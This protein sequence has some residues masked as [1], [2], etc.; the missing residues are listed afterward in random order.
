MNSELIRNILFD[1]N[2]P[3]RYMGGEFNLP[4]M[5]KPCDVRVCLCF[6]DV[7]EVGMSNIGLRILYHMLNDEDRVICER[8]FAPEDDMADKMRENSIPLFSLETKRELASFDIVGFSIGYEMMYTNVLFM[9]ELA[10]IPLR[11]EDRGEDGPLVI[12]GGMCAVNGEP[13]A[14]FFD[15]ILVGEGEVNLKDLTLRYEK[16]KKDGIKKSEFLKSLVGVNGMY[17]PSI[18]KP[19]YGENGKIVAF[20]TDKVVRS[21]VKDLDKAYFPTKILVPNIEIV[22]D[23]GVLEL[24]R[25]CANGCRFCQACFYYR[26]IRERKKETLLRYA[27]EILDNT[28]YNELSLASLSTGDFSQLDS[29]IDELRPIVKERNASLSLPSLRLDSFSGKFSEDSRKGS[30][31]FAPE[32]GTQRLRNVINKNVT[33][34]NIDNTMK[35]AAEQGYKGVKLYFMIGLPT[36]TK[37]DLDGIVE[38]VKRTQEIFFKYGDRNKKPRISLST[39]VFVP[40]PLTPFEWER[41]ITV[42]EMFEKQN[43]LKSELSKLINVRY[44]YHDAYTSLIEAVLARGDRKLSRV[45]ERVYKKGSHFDAWSEHFSFD[46]WIEAMREE[47]IS[48]DEYVGGFD[49]SDILPWDNIDNGVDK[50]YLLTERKRAYAGIVTPSCIGKCNGCRANKLGRCYE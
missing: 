16:A 17:V 9:L 10:G 36:E 4:N 41:Q 39:A 3:S 22:H 26:P 6:P 38:I 12:A 24:Y 46:N 28:G 8:C 29:L 25:G 11:A 47:G 32:A 5:D 14:D 49:E 50:E 40:K 19:I 48:V 44:S 37:E 33:D 1:V 18:T 15:V 13:F 7:Y 31:T 42:D 45:I 27:K 20:T 2:K 34:E 23:R 35:I 43:Y 21:I 30:L